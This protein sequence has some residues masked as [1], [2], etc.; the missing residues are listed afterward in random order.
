M[1]SLSEAI[2]KLKFKQTVQNKISNSSDSTEQSQ[3]IAQMNDCGVHPEKYLVKLDEDANCSTVAFPN[4][5]DILDDYVQ[6]QKTLPKI[7]SNVEEM[8]LF[9]RI[10]FKRHRVSC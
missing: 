5:Q 9:D 2:K 7:I 8:N 4:L 1:F 6:D 10:S 3:I